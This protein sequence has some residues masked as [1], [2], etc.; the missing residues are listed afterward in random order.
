M[1]GKKFCPNCGGENITF[2][3]GGTIGT[4]ICKTCG[5]SGALFPEKEIILDKV[6]NNEN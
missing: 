6:V 5:Y 3:A 1:I 4:S 2:V